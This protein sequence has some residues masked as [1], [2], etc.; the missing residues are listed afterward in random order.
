MDETTTRGGDRE[1]RGV[2]ETL[3]AAAERLRQEEEEIRKEAQEA[4]GRW[5]ADQ[6]GIDDLDALRRFKNYWDTQD[7]DTRPCGVILYLRRAPLID[8]CTVFG[9][10]FLDAAEATAFVVEHFSEETD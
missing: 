3:A 5:V 9:R 10:A 6:A 1:R 4:A 7:P 8:P 2:A